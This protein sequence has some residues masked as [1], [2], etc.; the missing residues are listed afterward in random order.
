MTR[1]STPTSAEWR[2]LPRERHCFVQLLLSPSPK[3]WRG[4]SAKWVP[5][6]ALGPDP[7]LGP[8]RQGACD[9]LP[10]RRLW[11]KPL[12]AVAG[13]FKLMAPA[14]EPYLWVFGRVVFWALLGAS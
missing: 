14:D 4:K 3:C 7:P 5:E 1:A 8:Y 10:F 9:R 6:F 12:A 2:G 13:L 11:A